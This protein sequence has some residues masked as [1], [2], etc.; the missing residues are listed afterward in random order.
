M[1]RG[2]GLFGMLDNH[3][4]LNIVSRMNIANHYSFQGCHR[5]NGYFLPGFLR[6]RCP[7]PTGKLTP[8]L[9]PDF[10]FRS[11]LHL[12]LHLKLILKKQR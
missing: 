8:T 11:Y 5:S 1:I 12:Y 10:P 6:T 3:L 7:C 9:T 2:S 4:E